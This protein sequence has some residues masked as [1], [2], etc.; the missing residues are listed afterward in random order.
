MIIFGDSSSQEDSLIPPSSFHQLCSILLPLS[1]RSK[2]DDDY[3]R[4]DR[5]RER[6]RR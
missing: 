3:D 5:D 6:E 2:D 1:R 4:R